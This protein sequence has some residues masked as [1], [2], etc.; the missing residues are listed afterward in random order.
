ML[1]Q[2]PGV[3][4]KV[5]LRSLPN[6]EFENN[7]SYNYRQ[8][9][10]RIDRHQAVN[11]STLNQTISISGFKA[12]NQMKIRNDQV[13]I[14]IVGYDV[15]I[16]DSKIFENPIGIQLNGKNNV[17]QDTTVKIINQYNAVPLVAGILISGQN[18]TIKNSVVEG[19]VSNELS[20]P[21]DILIDNSPT[22]DLPISGFIINTKLLDPHPIYFGNP[23]NPKSFLQIFG[24]DAPNT[25]KNNYPKNFILQKIDFDDIN[26]DEKSVDL[27]FVAKVSPLEGEDYFEGLDLLPEIEKSS[28]NLNYEKIQLFK[29]N[30][31]GWNNQVISDNEISA[32]VKIMM[33]EGLI[34]IPLVD[35]DN[36]DAYDLNLPSWMKRTAGFWIGDSISDQE[37]FNAI[38]FVLEHK[39][40]RV[41]DSYP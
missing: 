29:N 40:D 33:E 9:G 26:Q 41:F 10:L 13:G 39:L 35:L 37:F 21:S 38:E 25:P 14:K 16:K 34:R 30:V 17:V 23:V 12:W 32:E 5:N 20:S 31:I 18:M 2:P 22:L 3:E 8:E 19:Y 4:N 11:E 24:F 15:H 28:E 36:L 1:V 27:N 7:I 6:L